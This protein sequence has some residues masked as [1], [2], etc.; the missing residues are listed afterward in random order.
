[1]KKSKLLLKTTMLLA[2][3]LV[4][5]I[6]CNKDEEFQ[7]EPA[8]SADQLVTSAD[9]K[10]RF[11]NQ[12]N[13]IHYTKSQVRDM[14]LGLS[15]KGS[16]GGG[17]YQD[18]LALVNRVSNSGID[19][20]DVSTADNTKLYIVGAGVGSPAA[21]AQNID[22]VL[23][24]I[25]A[26]VSTLANIKNKPIGGI[27]SG[28]SGSLN[29]MIA[30]LLSQRLNVPLINGDGSG[31]AVPLL[32][33]SS[34]AHEAFGVAPMVV[35]APANPGSQINVS[36]PTD[37]TDA[38][39]KIRNIISQP[40]Y[41]NIGGVALWSQTG[42][43]LKNS[44]IIRNTFSDA[45]QLGLA[46]KSTIAT[47]NTSFLDN[48]FINNGSFIS[49]YTGTLSNFTETTVH[50]LDIVTLEV[51]INDGTGRTLKM[52]ALNEDLFLKISDGTV[53]TAP[54][55]MSY[56]IKDTNG[57]FVP[58]NNG[59]KAKMQSL[60]GKEIHIVCSYAAR[61]L[62]DFSNTFLG[63][64]NVPPFNYHGGVVPPAP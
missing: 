42:L 20:Y 22:G 14:Y 1:M 18:G 58:Y 60:V 2:V 9:Q 64:L 40:G 4:G 45:Y 53:I 55:L 54:H 11:F 25:E 61:R 32:S 37:A 62:Y 16:G 33:N 41:G 50:G 43:Q 38:E 7:N 8:T 36:N 47:G 12:A 19:L 6:A 27:L 26:S 59:D 46:T 10:G 48:Y 15:I 44:R 5:F 13:V 39:T 30:I 51:N 21:V 28:E 3:V 49:S 31:R 29:S 57:K 52:Q 17:A 24:A 56:V 23:N 34:Y 35:T 63:I